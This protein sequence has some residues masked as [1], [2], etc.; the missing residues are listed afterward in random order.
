MGYGGGVCQVSSTI[1]AAILHNKNFKVTARK[2][3]GLPATYIPVDM[4]ATVSYGSVDLKFVNKYPFK[5]R[6]NVKSEDGV[7]L[8]TITR[9]E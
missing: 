6:L 1:Y 4:D 7:C 3:H 8:V 5:V 2:P 9:A